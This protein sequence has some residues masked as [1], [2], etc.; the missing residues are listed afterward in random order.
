MP[1]LITVTEMMAIPEGDELGRD[2]ETDD[3]F[4]HGDADVVGRCRR[5]GANIHEDVVGHICEEGFRQHHDGA[6]ILP[7]QEAE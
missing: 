3:E 6:G 1:R 7:V 5:C 2:P 4:D